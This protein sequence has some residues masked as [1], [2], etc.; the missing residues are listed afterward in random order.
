MTGNK[1]NNVIVNHWRAMQVNELL[2]GTKAHSL[3]KNQRG[4]VVKN[5]HYRK[6]LKNVRKNN[7]V[8]MSGK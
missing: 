6:C 4:P 7:L 5:S 3:I 2:H 8:Y 1:A